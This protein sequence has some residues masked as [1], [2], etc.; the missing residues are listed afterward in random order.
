MVVFRG[1]YSEVDARGQSKPA[2]VATDFVPAS[3]P[4]GQSP[5]HIPRRKMHCLRR[6]NRDWRGVQNVFNS[7]QRWLVTQIANGN[8]LTIRTLLAESSHG[9]HEESEFE[10]SGFVQSLRKQ[11]KVVFVAVRDG[12]CMQTLQAVLRPEQGRE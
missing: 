1:D 10:V 11:K 8:T 9:Q 5:R 7:Q 2:T 6:T 12:S 3:R 4:S